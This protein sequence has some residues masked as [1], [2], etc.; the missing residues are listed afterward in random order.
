MPEGIRSAIRTEGR[1]AIRNGANL[2]VLHWVESALGTV[3]LVIIAR[4]LGATL[5]GYWSYGITSYVLVIGLTGFGFDSLMAI[6]LGGEK[7]EVGR[8]LGLTLTLRIALLVL[9][10]VAIIGYALWVE[11]NP[12]SRLVLLLLV[13]ALIGRGL[14][15]WVR[16]CFLAFERM[17]LHV[18]FVGLLRLAEVGTGA[19]YLFLGGGLIGLVLIHSACWLVEGIVGLARVRRLLN[20]WVISFDRREGA[21]LLRQGAVLGLS[22]GL[23]NWLLAGP[24]ILIRYVAGDMAELAQFAVLQNMTM[25]IVNSGLSLFA[26]ALP[27]LSR[28]IGGGDVRMAAYGRIIL[29]A[30]SCIAAAVSIFGWMLGPPTI[31]WIL[32]PDYSTAGELIGPFLL[33]GGLILAPMG[34][35]QSLLVAGFRWPTTIASFCAAVLLLTGLPLGFKYL[36]IEGAVLATGAAWA[37]RCLI[38]VGIALSRRR[39]QFK[40]TASR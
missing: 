30:S 34:Y 24:V 16:V 32:G 22:G 9:G 10:T 12:T 14:A 19:S 21:E 3:Y 8:Y 25:I 39:S 36:G 31:G 26:G 27:A 37:S 33:I 38:V 6:R 40:M 4:Q 15:I 23:F 35:I 2:A 13:P 28:A 5:Y 18:K 1:S 11:P 29:V 17:S 20:P 7:R